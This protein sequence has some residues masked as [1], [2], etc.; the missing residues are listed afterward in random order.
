MGV[1]ARGGVAV[2]VMATPTTSSIVADAD[3]DADA[4]LK[5]VLEAAL[6]LLEVPPSLFVAA[7]LSL[8]EVHT[9]VVL[10]PL[11]WREC[12]RAP[13]GGV[14]VLL[15]GGPRLRIVLVLVVGCCWFSRGVITREIT[16]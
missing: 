5:Y 6:L 10:G 4:E 1:R 15:A 2:A 11:R 12:R 13:W 14:R 9:G 8:F 7:L 3:A 16:Y